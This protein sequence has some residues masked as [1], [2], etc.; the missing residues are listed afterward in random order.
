MRRGSAALIAMFVTVGLLLAAPL[1]P[2]S[3]PYRHSIAW[4]VPVE[5]GPIVEQTL[6]RGAATF[7]MRADEYRRHT[8]PHVEHIGGKT[9]ISLVTHRSD[10]GGSYIACY[11]QQHLVISE[12]ALGISFGA[13]TLW[14]R[15][16]QWVW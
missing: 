2:L 9:C 12:R 15:F 4:Q 7:G 16:G 10:A 5:H 13:E 8:R 11:D 14:D 1:V 6:V 3:Q